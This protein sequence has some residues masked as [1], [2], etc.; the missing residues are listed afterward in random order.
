MGSFSGPSV[1]ARS[2]S[3]PPPSVP[4]ASA[5]VVPGSL[6]R[7]L[8]VPWGDTSL[9][10]R[11]CADS[12]CPVDLTSPPRHDPL[13]SVTFVASPLSSVR[14]PAG[15]LGVGDASV[16]PPLMAS[17]RSLVSGC[18]VSA[19]FGRDPVSATETLSLSVSRPVAVDHSVAMPVSSSALFRRFLPQLF[20]PLVGIW[21]LVICCLL[22]GTP[23][24]S[25]ES[26]MHRNLWLLV[27]P[28]FYLLLVVLPLPQCVLQWTGS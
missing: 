7:S 25:F 27:R 8:A 17:S 11:P 13:M 22:H 21:G 16:E 18:S 28:W 12:L 24:L 9:G 20:L 6:S 23:F 1:P 15:V 4:G 14:S 26:L 10:D 5:S 3:A 19:S 2:V